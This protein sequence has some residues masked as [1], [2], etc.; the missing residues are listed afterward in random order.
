MIRYA[1]HGEE[2]ISFFAFLSVISC[3]IG[4]LVVVLVCVTITSFWGAELVVEPIDLPSTG[5]DAGPGRIY[6]ECRAD[7]LIVHPHDL[8]VSL[9]DLEDPSRWIGGPYGQALSDVSSHRGAGSVFFLV[10][11]GG[12]PVFRKALGYAMAVGGGTAEDSEQG[13]ATFSIG[14]QRVTM[15]GPIRVGAPGEENP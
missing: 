7:G 9:D 3:T 1:R 4:V 15:P 10:R 14:Q 11:R 13:T 12:L 2:G 8:I 5:S 6:V